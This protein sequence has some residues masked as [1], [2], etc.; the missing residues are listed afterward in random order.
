MKLTDIKHSLLEAFFKNTSKGVDVDRTLDIFIALKNKLATTYSDQIADHPPASSQDASKAFSMFSRGHA[1]FLTIVEDDGVKSYA[2]WA[3]AR[4]G[5]QIYV[6]DLTTEPHVEQKVD[7]KSVR[8][9][10]RQ[11][12]NINDEAYFNVIS[13][14]EQLKHYLIKNAV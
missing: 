3:A 5:K 14:T 8:A 1:G 11:A 9:A 4:I 2:I 6:V 7:L 13:V 10:L 12:K